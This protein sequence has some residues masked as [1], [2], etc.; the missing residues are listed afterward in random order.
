[1]PDL[2]TVV[3]GAV[4]VLFAAFLKGIVG[5]GFVSSA[6]VGVLAVGN[7]ASEFP[8]ALVAPS[9]KALPVDASSGQA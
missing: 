7:G 6:D 8:I 9:F 2:A 1:M 4:V 3:A 5:F